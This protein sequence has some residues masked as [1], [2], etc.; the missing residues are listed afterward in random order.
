MRTTDIVRRRNQTRRANRRAARAGRTSAIAAL[1]LALLSVLAPV[2][3]AAG[4]L[5]LLLAFI[6]GLPDVDTLRQ[7]P[8]RYQPYASTTHLYAWDPPDSQGLRHP[9]L[10]DT[11]ADPRA[12]S[13]GWIRLDTLPPIVV[14][15][16]LAASD[17]TF[18]DRPPPALAQAALDWWQTGAVGQQSPFLQDLVTD[19]L[20]DGQA[21]PPGDNHRALQDWFLARQIDHRFGRE[22]VLEWVL[23]TTYYGHLAYGIEA[24]A[25]VY[26]GKSAA[27]LTTGEAALLAAVAQAPAANPFDD[28]DAARAGQQ[29]VLA[30]LVGQGAIT[31]AE[32]IAEAARPLDLVPPPGSDASAP[33]FARLA[34]AE[35]ERLLGPERLVRGGL[36]VETTLDTALQE[37]ASCAAAAASSPTAPAG[38]GPPCPAAAALTNHDPLTAAAIVVLNPDTGAIEALVAGEGE[39]AS[40]PIGTLARPFIALTAL[41]QGYTPASLTYDLERIYLE[42][43]RPTIPRNTDG[44]YVG[45]LRL[46]EALTTGRTAAAAHMLSWV[47]A[48]RVLENA[49]ALGLR[50]ADDT[51]AGLAFAERGF[52]A[53]LL[54]LSHAFAAI[55]NGGTMAGAPGDDWPRPA[56][57][58]LIRDGNEELYAFAPTEQETLGPEL[59]W[60]LTDMLAIETP[61]LGRVALAAGHSADT[62]DE[63]AI[64][65]TTERL[66]GVWTSGMGPSPTTASPAGE[67]WRGLLAVA[68]A[69]QPAGAWPRPPGLRA[70]DVCA[71]SGQ[72]PRRGAAA[73]RTIREYFIPGTEPVVEDAMSREVAVNRETGRLAT[74]FTPPHLIERH[75]FTVYPAEAAAWAA[76]QGIPA[77]P[78]EYDTI[79]R[80]PTRAGG[81]ALSVEPWSVVRGLISVEGSAGGEGFDIYRLAYFPNLLPE[82]VQPLV[83]RGETPVES[84]VLGMWDTTLIDNGL[85]ILLLTVVR[86][87]GT[88]D[89]V[90]IPVIVSNDR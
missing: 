76:A 75:V 10:V 73:C 69:G 38:G 8:V 84:A 68:Q 24:A 50:P 58:R 11:I 80:V 78:T 5:A 60:L 3:V 72:L 63:W 59:A 29:A 28:P 40:R 26:L 65:Y 66:I 21:A 7:L 52:T 17:P 36:Q 13:A 22:Q 45:P 4:G 87:D 88:F 89:E 43:G 46:R 61:P 37:Q 54:S 81:A 39:L 42:D 70:V 19:H 56:T 57:I 32:A 67:I 20:R 6:R 14:E 34:R 74:I 85:Y 41:S 71:L 23:N 30:T 1:S 25:R 49:R 9:V 51:P 2:V 86:A 79:R 90:A 83:E 53:D 35:L 44:A 33:A 12:G 55:G 64:G 16:T 82:A 77:P 47:G 18:L 27:E 31:T 62:G 15:A 48:G